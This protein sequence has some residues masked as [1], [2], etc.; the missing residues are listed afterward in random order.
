[1]HFYPVPNRLQKRVD[2]QPE[3]PV[4]PSRPIS[5]LELRRKRLADCPRE[6]PLAHQ[7]QLDE[8]REQ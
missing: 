4:F 5:L 6:R 8:Y 1:L 7:E 3:H 2:C